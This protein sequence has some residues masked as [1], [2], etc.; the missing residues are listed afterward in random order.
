MGASLGA[1][2]AAIAGHLTDG[3]MGRITG[4]DPSGPLHYSAKPSLKYQLTFLYSFYSMWPK[5][6]LKMAQVGP[7]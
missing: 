1:H 7:F 2:A 4:L 3:K 5:K 6:T